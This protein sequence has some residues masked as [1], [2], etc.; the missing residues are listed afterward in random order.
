MLSLQPG[1]YRR[2]PA[3]LLFLFAV[4]LAGCSVSGYGLDGKPVHR[5][6]PFPAYKAL[7]PLERA[8]ADSMLAFAL[9]HEALYSLIGNIKPIS[10]TGY[11]FVNGLGKDSTDQNGQAVVVMPEQDSVRQVLDELER[12]NNITKAL[13]FGP[14]RFIILPFR[15]TWNGRRNFQIAV[16]RTDL[17]D[18]LLSDHAAF[19]AQWGFV[20]GSDPAVLLTAVEF[21]D[22]LDRYRA[23]GYLFGYP[24]HAV[25]FFVE[26]A[27]EEEQT[28]EFVHRDFFQIPV[29]ARSNGYFTYAVPKDYQPIDRDSSLYYRSTA[30]LNRYRAMRPRYLDKNGR[31]KAVRLLRKYWKQAQ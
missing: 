29:H 6:K 15:Q 19:F 3:W 12:W 25:D 31:L 16:C 20:P 5:L 18:R 30:V 10:Q 17:V 4:C 24:K 22:T 9:D 8:M 7:S 23:Y 1:S 2:I 14:Y 13:S 26:A 27:R 21:E 28:G 11:I